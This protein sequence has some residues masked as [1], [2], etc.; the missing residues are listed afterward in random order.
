MNEVQSRA[1]IDVTNLETTKE[2]KE[3]LEISLNQ[4]HLEREEE[5]QCG[6][7]WNK[8]LRKYLRLS[9]TTHKKRS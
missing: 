7:N 1:R 9:Q 5:K 8:G 3:I 6:E 2:V 4:V